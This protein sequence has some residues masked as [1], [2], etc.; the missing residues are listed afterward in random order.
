[1]NI[2]AHRV[3]KSSGEW[4]ITNLSIQEFSSESDDSDAFYSLGI[5]PWD[6]PHIDIDSSLNKIQIATG[7]SER[8]AS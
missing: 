2:H 7:N 6:I 1:M 5:H 8:N 4:V 3:S